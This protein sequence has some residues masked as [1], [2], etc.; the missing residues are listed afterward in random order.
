[1]YQ[2]DYEF[3]EEFEFLHAIW[4]G[5]I[6]GKASVVLG[7]RQG[8]R[9]LL[10]LTWRNDCYFMEQLDHNCGPAN[11]YGFTRRNKD[12]LIAANREID[13]VALYEFD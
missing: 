4:S 8:D 11:V 5:F 13:E 2:L 12:I 6:Q 10:R 7:H 1:M 9:N 3:E